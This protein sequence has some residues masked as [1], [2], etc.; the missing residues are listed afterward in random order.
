MKSLLVRHSYWIGPLLGF[1][2]T[3][4][5]CISLGWQIHSTP[6][7]GELVF[8]R[9]MV[10]DRELI[11]I[12]RNIGGKDTTLSEISL[13]FS[14]A[15]PIAFEQ[16]TLDGDVGKK[17]RNIHLVKKVIGSSI[18]VSLPP[19]PDASG[20][21]RVFGGRSDPYIWSPLSNTCNEQS[22]RLPCAV[23]PNHQIE[24][25]I[26]KRNAPAISEMFFGGSARFDLNS[27]LGNSGSIRLCMMSN[28]G[29]NICKN[30][31]GLSQS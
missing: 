19:V 23:Q 12:V 11:F 16:L 22:T 14:D 2:G 7:D 31:I 5:A 24:I 20:A 15:I 8:D 30:S 21:I 3:I 25:R 9:E 29:E 1:I 13:E 28:S 4:V 26:L 18:G 6:S 10:S 27:S 17:L